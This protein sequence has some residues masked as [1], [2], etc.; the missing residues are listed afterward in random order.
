MET[1]SKNYSIVYSLYGNYRGY[2]A[3]LSKRLY[4]YTI[5][6]HDM[7]FFGFCFLFVFCFSLLGHYC[8]VCSK[9]K[10]NFLFRLRSFFPKPSFRE[11]VMSSSSAKVFQVLCLI[12]VNIYCWGKRNVVF[13]SD[14]CLCISITY[15]PGVPICTEIRT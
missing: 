15:P 7:N 1:Q 11:P 8:K 4:S 5:Q 12:K 14:L 9:K 3:V 13:D 2:L 10:T 6:F